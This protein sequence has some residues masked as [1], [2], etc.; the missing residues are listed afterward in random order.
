[1]AEPGSW[2]HTSAPFNQD[3]VLSYVE[4]RTPHKY[5][6]EE[7][8][9]HPAFPT[10]LPATW[11]PR[12]YRIESLLLKVFLLNCLSAWGPSL[13]FSVQ[14]GLTPLSHTHTHFDVG[15]HL[16]FLER[17]QLLLHK[18]RQKDE[19]GC[20]WGWSHILYFPHFIFPYIPLKPIELFQAFPK[21][22][23]TKRNDRVHR[24]II[25]NWMLN[26]TSPIV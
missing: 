13:S 18:C 4:C 3:T 7:C 16:K 11:G 20:G 1:M 23:V 6:S 8:I 26:I 21:A 22:G 5:I 9:C 10:P 25:L 15:L 12:F 24:K 2:T 17:V 19:W 14:R